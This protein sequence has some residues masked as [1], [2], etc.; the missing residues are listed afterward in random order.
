MIDRK[1]G[2]STLEVKRNFFI[3]YRLYS[4]FDH[5]KPKKP[6]AFYCKNHWSLTCWGG[7]LN[8]LLNLWL[9]SDNF[10]YSV[11][12]P[13]QAKE[14]N[15]VSQLVKRSF[16][17][18]LSPFPYFVAVWFVQIFLQKQAPSPCINNSLLTSKWNS[19]F[20]RFNYWKLSPVQ[21]FQI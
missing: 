8:S 14:K 20:P 12:S 19:F 7:I 6:C 13:L 11:L 2:P 17:A 1:H 10:H 4:F 15:L 5:Q 3:S 9:A 16:L 18:N 21:S